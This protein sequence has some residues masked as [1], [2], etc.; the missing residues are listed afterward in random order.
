[1]VN[2]SASGI[3]SGDVGIYVTCDRGREK[4]S[5]R[6]LHDLVLEVSFFVSLYIQQGW[7]GTYQGRVLIANEGAWRGL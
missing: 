2:F 3:E 4:Q 7:M 1:M 5:L 6:E